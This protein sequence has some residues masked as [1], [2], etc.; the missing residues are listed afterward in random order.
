[1]RI[2]VKALTLL[3]VTIAVSVCALAAPSVDG[4]LAARINA[5]PLS[6]TPVVITFDHGVTKM[7]F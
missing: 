2:L 1:M 7:T 6:L 5:A 3:V 4:L